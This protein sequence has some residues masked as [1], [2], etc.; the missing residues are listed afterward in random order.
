MVGVP[1]RVWAELGRAHM[2]LGQALELPAGSGGRAGPGRKAPIELF[3]GGLPFAHG[4]LA[5]GRGDGEW[6]VQVDEL[7]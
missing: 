4:S 6:A 3:V 7:V 1:V 2:P 5:G